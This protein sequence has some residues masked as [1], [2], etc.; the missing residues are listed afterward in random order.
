MQLV[1]TKPGW[2]QCLGEG[3]SEVKKLKEGDNVS[4]VKS[5]SRP[6]KSPLTAELSSLTVRA[7]WAA[8]QPGRAKGLCL[9]VCR[10]PGNPV[11]GL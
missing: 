6:V 4:E 3:Y 11:A 1:R 10:E 7:D 8:P 9:G 5:S 2:Q